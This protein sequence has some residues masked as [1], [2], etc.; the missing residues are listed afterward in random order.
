M[1]TRAEERVLIGLGGNI[2]DPIASMRAALAALDRHPDCRVTAVSSIWRTPPWGVTDQ[3]DFFNACAAVYTTLD[4]Q[5]FLS[6]CLTIE[7]ELKRVRDQRWG[8]RSIDIDILFFGERVI[9][10]PGLVVPHPRLWERAFV[11]VPLAE[12]APETSH[13]GES[14]ADLADMADKSGMSVAETDFRF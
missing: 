3:P 5:A 14:V 9:D 7:K 2:G 4:P 10:E 8:P 13:G 6:L 11:L 1:S 12:I